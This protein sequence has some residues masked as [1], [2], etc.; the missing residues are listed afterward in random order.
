MPALPYRFLEAELHPEQRV[1]RVGG[2]DCQ[3]GAR[4][5]DLLLAL[6]ERR[7]RVVPKGELFGSLT[8]MLATSKVGF[9]LICCVNALLLQIRRKPRR[10]RL[11]GVISGIISHYSLPKSFA[12]RR[13]GGSISTSGSGDAN[14]C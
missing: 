12:D 2:R 13:L 9:G 7:D 3:V 11:A 6:V 8:F 5:F 10:R 14:C 4:A 1:L